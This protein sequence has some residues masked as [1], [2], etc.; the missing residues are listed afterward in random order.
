MSNRLKRNPNFQYY[1]YQRYNSSKK[2]NKLQNSKSA[3]ILVQNQMRKG[4]KLD[5]EIKNLQ[6]KL[7]DKDY[8]GYK[9]DHN[10]AEP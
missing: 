1:F 5:K 9:N 2:L 6:R 10:Y 8:F 4:E 7:E 3:K